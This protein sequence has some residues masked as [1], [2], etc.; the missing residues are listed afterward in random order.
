[1]CRRT[2]CR[3]R[4]PWQAF[5][6]ISNS[7]RTSVSIRSSPG[8]RPP[9]S[10]RRTLSERNR[11][12]GSHGINC[13]VQHARVVSRSVLRF[14]GGAHVGGTKRSA[15]PARPAAHGQTHPSTW[16]F[17]VSHP[18]R[19][20]FFWVVGRG[21]RPV[22][23]QVRRTVH[24]GALGPTP[25]P[26]AR[27]RSELVRGGGVAQIARGIRHMGIDRRSVPICFTSP[28]DIVS[29]GEPATR[30]SRP[31]QVRPRLRE[32]HRCRL[33]LQKGVAAA[34]F[35]FSPALCR[36][37]LPASGL[38]VGG[39]EERRSRLFKPRPLSRRP[40]SATVRRR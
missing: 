28:Q 20:F 36:F 23:A 6:R 26:G 33:V 31:N 10:A 18:A 11:E 1:M 38:P 12:T 17:F 37:R 16:P 14:L 39:C 40:M 29:M 8:L 15:L 3:E 32:N 7:R 13:G 27:F 22:D 19:L 30:G 21:A 35:E 9:V 24:L 5:C 4:R 25:A 34:F 2:R